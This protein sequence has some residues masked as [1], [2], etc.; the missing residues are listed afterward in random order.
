MLVIYNCRSMLYVMHFVRYV[1]ALVIDI[2][3][4]MLYVMPFVRCVFVLA[5]YF[6]RAMLYVMQ[7]VHYVFVLAVHVCRV[8]APFSC[9]CSTSAS[10]HVSVGQ[11]HS[12]GRLMKFEER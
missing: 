12:P 11:T 10:R 2:C 8:C 9:W 6:C 7:F 3:R 5:I 1:F 4:A